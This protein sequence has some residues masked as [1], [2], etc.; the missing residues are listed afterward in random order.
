M[1]VPHTHAPAEAP[2]TGASPHGSP[3]ETGFDTFWR[4]WE[5]QVGTEHPAPD[6]TPD[7]A[8]DFQLGARAVTAHDAVIADVRSKLLVGSYASSPQQREEQVVMHV[9][10]HHTW[11]FARP[12]GDAYAIGA[13]DFLI[14]RSGPPTSEDARDTAATVLLLP[15]APLSSVIRDRL[16]PGPTSSPE[17]RLL[18]GHMSLV[19]QTAQDLTPAGALAARNALVELVHGVLRQRA[20]NAEPHLG[21]AL[22]QAAKDLMETRLAD[23]D[24]SPA[25][26]AR[27]L[28]VSVRT[29]HRAFATS[30][31]SVTTYLRHR[32]L[33]RARL[34]LLAATNRPTITELA[35]RWQFADSSHFTRAFKSRYGHTPTAYARATAPINDPEPPDHAG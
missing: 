35:A 11:H 5:E 9:V 24:L 3:A 27:E 6:F 18:L 32:R 8:D 13:G 17:V 28:G 16:V 1:T 20:D 23:P 31:E 4:A 33:D 21:P 14:Q 25:T 22:A 7:G 34:A 12:R 10:R 19:G 15:A 2:A 26:L 29:L 30:D